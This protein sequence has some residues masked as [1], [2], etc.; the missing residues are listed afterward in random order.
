MVPFHAAFRITSPVRVRR[1]DDRPGEC[2]FRLIAVPVPVLSISDGAAE[3]VR[4]LHPA[5]GAEMLS[6]LEPNDQARI[7]TRL[8]L[9][10]GIVLDGHVKLKAKAKV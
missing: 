1:P 4:N 2:R 10:D 3:Y 9:E 6:E 7:V 8:E 5:D